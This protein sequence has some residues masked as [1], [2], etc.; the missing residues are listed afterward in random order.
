MR[1]GGD[2][3]F[4]LNGVSDS[5]NSTDASD[6][7]GNEEIA[8]GYRFD[9]GFGYFNGKMDETRISSDGRLPAW[10]EANFYTQTDALVT[11]GGERDLHEAAVAIT[12]AASLAAEG[13]LLADGASAISMTLD[14]AS[15]GNRIT[16]GVVAIG[17]ETT[18]AM[19]GGKLVQAAM[20]ITP[21]MVMTAIGE[22]T[23]GGSCAI[24]MALDLASEANALKSGV[25]AISIEVDLSAVP[26]YTA[27]GTVAI[28]PGLA[29]A[30]VGGRFADAAAAITPAVS[31]SA[32]PIRIIQAGTVAITLDMTMTAAAIRTII[33]ALGLSGDL[34]AGST[35][36]IDSDKQTFKIDGVN[37]LK[38]M[39]GDFFNIPPGESVVEYD[40]D[41]VAR[42]VDVEIEYDPR[43]A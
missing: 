43:D 41:E 22:A 42:D 29:L 33:V 27:D 28:T 23:A 35:W 13:N 36:A 1:S 15:I 18:L 4:Y 20:G 30:A 25:L 2:F 6:L 5:G 17:L 14:L 8:L 24:A 7:D 31:L 32:I 21:E 38:D 34:G 10:I 37:V 11:W 3:H 40:D 12:P 9:V 39:V 19:L 16:D 26:N